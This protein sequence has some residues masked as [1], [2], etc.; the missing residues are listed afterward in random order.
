MRR[1]AAAVAAGARN[2]HEGRF[3]CLTQKMGTREMG[4]RED[5]HV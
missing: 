2:E 4:T 1:L 5:L 3:T